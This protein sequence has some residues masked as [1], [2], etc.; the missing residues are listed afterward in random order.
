MFNM[1]QRQHLLVKPT[2]QGLDAYQLSFT[3]H[4]F[5]S[6]QHKVVCN[7][8]LHAECGGSATISL[9]VTTE[10]YQIWPISDFILSQDTLYHAKVFFSLYVSSIS[11]IYKL[12][13]LV[14]QQLI[15]NIIFSFFIRVYFIIFCDYYF[16][17]LRSFGGYFE[18]TLFI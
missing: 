11:I 5:P 18:K 15:Q 2:K 9:E 17:L 14:S 8:H 16:F 3:T 12:Y 13:R 10:I 7:Q 6:E 4:L 1:A